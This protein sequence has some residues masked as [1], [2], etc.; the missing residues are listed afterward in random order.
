MENCGKCGG[1]VFKEVDEWR[2]WQCGRY[3]YVRLDFMDFPDSFPD[4]DRS[5]ALSDDSDSG[6]RSRRSVRSI[7]SR[8][9]AGE[10]SDLQWWSRNRDVIQCLEQGLSIREIAIGL[11]LGERQVRVVRQRLD[12]LRAS[13]EDQRLN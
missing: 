3:Y 2:C 5:R 13:T 7:N 4:M 6:H 9:A 8:I 1:S 10:S 12:D 11:E